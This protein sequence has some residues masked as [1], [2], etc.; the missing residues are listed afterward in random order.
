MDV[1]S[2]CTL[3]VVS[4]SDGT[5]YIETWCVGDMRKVVQAHPA[6]DPHHL[7]SK[8]VMFISSNVGPPVSPLLSYHDLWGDPAEDSWSEEAW[9][10]LLQAVPKT[11]K[12]VGLHIRVLPTAPLTGLLACLSQPRLTNGGFIEVCYGI[13]SLGE[14]EKCVYTCQQRGVKVHVGKTTILEP[15]GE[16]DSLSARWD[17]LF[18]AKDKQGRRMVTVYS[19]RK[20]TGEEY[21]W[22]AYDWK[23]I[24]WN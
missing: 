10:R 5:L 16:K 3:L 1:Q 9:T 17:R 21:Q 12:T 8:V 24:T 22:T 18:E 19:R 13:A 14:V 7:M 11:W 20:Q 6:I 2:E 4:W 23:L 15:E